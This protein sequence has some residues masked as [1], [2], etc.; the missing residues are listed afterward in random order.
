M[1]TTLVYRGVIGV[2]YGVS[3]KGTIGSGLVEMAPP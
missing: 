2:I 1:E 3:R